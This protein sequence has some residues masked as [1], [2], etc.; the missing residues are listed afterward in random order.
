V[1]TSA[2]CE[3][4]APSASAGVVVPCVCSTGFR[5]VRLRG[6]NQSESNPTPKPSVLRRKPEPRAAHGGWGG[7]S[8]QHLASGVSVSVSVSVESRGVW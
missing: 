8:V 1:D 7:L 3:G 5:V 2:S 6:K 4:V